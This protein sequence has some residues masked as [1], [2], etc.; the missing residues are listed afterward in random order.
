MNLIDDEAAAIARVK[1]YVE[2]RYPAYPTDDLTASRF[3]LGW[4]VFPRRRDPDDFATLRPGQ[5]VF[6][7]G[8]SGDIMEASG[9]RPPHERTAEFT[10]RYG[11]AS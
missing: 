1:A 3:A 5:S 6:L 11:N 2:D 8:D 9:S 4:T 10:R 7:I